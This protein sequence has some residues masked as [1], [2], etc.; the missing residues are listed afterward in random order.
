MLHVVKLFKTSKYWEFF[1]L[2][3]RL[4]LKNKTDSFKKCNFN[5]MENNETKSNILYLSLIQSIQ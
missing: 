1:I 3:W 5:T 4:K 2:K